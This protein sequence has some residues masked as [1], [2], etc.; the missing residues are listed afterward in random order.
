[1]ENSKIKTYKLENANGVVVEF[2]AKG[3]KII[4][5][6]I[7]END[8]HTDIIVGYDTPDEF[9]N[10]DDY[11]GAICGRVANRI[12]DSEFS[13]HGIPYKLKAN[14][15]KN[16]LHGG[17]NGFQVKDWDIKS[18][19]LKD[20]TSAYELSLFSP[21]GDENYPGNLNVKIIYA[22]NNKN[23]FLID[24]QAN[25]DKDT[26]VNLTSHPYFNLNGVNRGKVFNHYLEVNAT[27]FT[28]INEESIPTGD[29]CDV[30]GTDMDFNKA[31]RI[32]DII[33]S[34]YDPI[35]A[36]QGLDHNFV[37]NKNDKEYGFA[38]RLSEPESGRSVEVY[39]TQPGVQ[40]YTGMHFDDIE[41]GKGG[42]PFQPYCGVAIEA[43]NFP[44][45]VNQPNFPNCIL[46]PEDTYDEK[47]VYKFSF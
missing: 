24:I 7:P 44:N 31:T 2:I 18:I 27:K 40:V 29:F 33:R 45:S 47:I 9:I 43:Q 37:I 14:E 19:D 38:C 8:S 30:E 21:D 17:S 4:S 15:G 25:T 28:P 10:G 12:S 22:L 3:G 35:H 26:V 32:G 11:L 20:Y 13:I 1:M 42:V 5:I 36:L 6:K 39:T 16:Q 23:E 41:I 46:T 34:G